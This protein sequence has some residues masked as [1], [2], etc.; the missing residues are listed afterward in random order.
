MKLSPSCLFINPPGERAQESLSYF[1]V[2]SNCKSRI[3]FAK[4]QEMLT[5][6][7]EMA[8]AAGKEVNVIY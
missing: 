5:G 2:I 1:I 3:L 4:D 8:E 6:I 7:G